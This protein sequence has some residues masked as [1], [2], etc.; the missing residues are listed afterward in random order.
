VALLA[1]LL[2][3]LGSATR[4]TARAASEVAAGSGG[5]LQARVALSNAAPQQITETFEVIASGLDNPRDLVFGP[6]G[7]LY[8][9]EAGNGGEEPCFPGPE[10][11]EVCYGTSGAVTRVSGGTQERIVTGLSSIAGLDG[12]N[13][14]GPHNISFGPDGTLY[15][16]VG[17]GADPAILEPG[18]TLELL[19]DDLGQ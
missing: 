17:L 15:V 5:D 6:D 1:A 16:L 10:G 4:P 18:G 8:V 19:G 9:T 13:A 11:G 3:V 7:N 2:V 14:T 12:S